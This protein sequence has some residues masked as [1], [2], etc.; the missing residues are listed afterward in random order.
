MFDPRPKFDQ[1]EEV[2]LRN[3]LR[4][5]KAPTVVRNFSEEI[6]YAK[7]IVSFPVHQR[8]VT[9]IEN[10]HETIYDPYHYMQNMTET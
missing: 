9:K 1:Q 6:E 7:K 2:K 3:L 5:A 4:K 8:V 10:M